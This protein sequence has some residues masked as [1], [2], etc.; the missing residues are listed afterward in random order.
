[1]T[2]TNS[3]RKADVLIALYIGIGALVLGLLIDKAFPSQNSMLTMF[4]IGLFASV[5]WNFTHWKKANPLQRQWIVRAIVWTF[6]V[7]VLSEVT[8]KSLNPVT[9]L[10]YV[11]L[12][13]SGF[14]AARPVQ[15]MV[16]EFE[17]ESKAKRNAPET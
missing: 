12:C 4:P 16:S 6:V 1:M 14:Y 13:S 9:A 2:S 10:V 8:V 3:H 15:E 11:A 7:M 17:K 5:F